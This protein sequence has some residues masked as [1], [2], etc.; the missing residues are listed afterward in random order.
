M[1]KKRGSG[2]SEK[3]AVSL[4][5]S[6]FVLWNMGF[7]LLFWFLRVPF[8]D[9]KHFMDQRPTDG[10]KTGHFGVHRWFDSLYVSI[11]T[12]T[13]VGAA[14]VVPVSTTGQILTGI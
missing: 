4:L 6:R 8:M 3:L 10:R 5:L 7:V 1:Q 12:Q 11:M 9:E 13:T 14:D 2:N